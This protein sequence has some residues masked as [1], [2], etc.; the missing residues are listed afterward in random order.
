M[1]IGHQIYFEKELR[2]DSQGKNLDYFIEREYKTFLVEGVSVRMC[3]ATEIM[4]FNNKNRHKEIIRLDRDG[5]VKERITYSWEGRVN[6]IDQYK[7]NEH[8]SR[9]IIEYD[10]N[11][12]HIKHESY[13]VERGSLVY[14]GTETTKYDAK[15]NEVYSA[16]INASR[17][18]SCWK[19]VTEYSNN[20]KNV[21]KSYYRGS[22]LNDFSHS[23]YF[24][25]DENRNVIEKRIVHREGTI[26]SQD[27]IELNKYVDGRIISH[28][29][30]YIYDDVREHIYEEDTYIYNENNISKIQHLNNRE[31]QYFYNQSGLLYL[32]L[33]LRDGKEESVKNYF[34][35]DMN[36]EIQRV[37][38]LISKNERIIYEYKYD[39]Y[40]N[41][42]YEKRIEESS[43]GGTMFETE[44]ELG[45][46][47]L[48]RKG[49]ALTPQ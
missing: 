27:S 15:G 25:H 47:R 18:H 8:I 42:I 9:D 3:V 33:N 40:G 12:R 49:T 43:K 20:G 24:T 16:W 19:W 6:I 35:D 36:N 41:K 23:L 14:R 37:W 5:K 13:D 17:N 21:K 28:V 46:R 7:H 31:T 29:A 2:E 22:H 11:F 32:E 44:W 34:Y 38:N 4:K 45:L 26:H 30:K 39:G 10:S 48:N 1:S